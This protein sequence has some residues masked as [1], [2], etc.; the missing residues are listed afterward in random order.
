MKNLKG[1]FQREPCD[2]TSAGSDLEW[3][4]E[5][6]GPENVHSD[7]GNISTDL[8]LSWKGRVEDSRWRSSQRHNNLTKADVLR[9]ELLI[10]DGFPTSCSVMSC[11]AAVWTIWFLFL[12]SQSVRSCQCVKSTVPH[13]KPHTQVAHHQR[14][15]DKVLDFQ[16]GFA[17]KSQV[18]LLVKGT[19]TYTWVYYHPSTDKHRI[20][21]L[22]EFW[23]VPELFVYG[24]WFV[25]HCESRF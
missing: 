3:N 17:L 15:K 10:L 20:C 2:L 5:T 23:L 11:P 9:I 8:Y 24:L 4:W 18:D 16:E 21:H 19:K 12:M 7:P 6:K 14:K 1:L 25:L 22:E 13:N